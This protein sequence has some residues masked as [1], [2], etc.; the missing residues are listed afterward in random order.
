[1]TEFDAVAVVRELDL[2]G[3]DYVLLGDGSGTSVGSPC[4]WAC[5]AV[6]GG[7]GVV[8]HRGG[9]SSGTSN[10]AE[11]MPYVL[12]LWHIQSKEMFRKLR[13]AIVSDSE[14]TVR[15]GNREYEK[16]ANCAFWACIDFYEGLGYDITWKHV[17]RN[18]NPIH[19]EC[20]RIAGI[21]RL[22]F[23]ESLKK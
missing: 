23:Q 17:K 8:A 1:M 2:K 16:R 4:G 12:A 6:D 14:L 9:C 19:A 13:I 20:D 15:C 5:F 21:E 3:F 18:T 11:L 22:R 7:G 10:L